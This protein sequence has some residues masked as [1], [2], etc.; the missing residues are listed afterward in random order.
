MNE[1]ENT[2]YGMLTESTGTH[3]LDSGGANGRHWQRN[4]KKSLEDFKSAPSAT[5]EISIYNHGGKE[6]AEFSKVVDLFHL[7]NNV[8]DLDDL[9]KEYNALECG[10]WNGD[11]YGTDLEQCE[12]LH[13]SG[14]VP[15]GESFNTY[16]WENNLSQVLIGQV[17]DHDITGDKYV[18][19][20]IH[21]GADVRGGYTDAKLF[22][23]KDHYEDYALFD[24]DV[25]FDDMHFTGSDID[26]VELGLLGDDDLLDI[27]KKIGV[28][29]YP[30]DASYYS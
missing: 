13:C 15:K 4:Q 3:M 24:A 10:N 21:N 16:N 2:I 22:R 1:L 19:L 12:F 7:L 8:L 20:Q 5:V 6:F 29:V 9:C 11:Y 27:A 23:L 28:G 18:L 17:F 30:A 26:H 25:L 14:L